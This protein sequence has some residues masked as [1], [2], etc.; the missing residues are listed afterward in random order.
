MM[1]YTPTDAPARINSTLTGSSINCNTV[2]SPKIVT[3]GPKGMAAR[4]IIAGTATIIGAR[5]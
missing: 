3:S 5:K 1:P 4:P 2:R